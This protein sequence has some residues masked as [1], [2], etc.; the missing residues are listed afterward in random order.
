MKRPIS[1]AYLELTAEL[2]NVADFRRLENQVTKA[3]NKRNKGHK[4]EGMAI[5]I[6]KLLEDAKK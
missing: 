3:A 5:L 2:E 6:M 1:S 4:E